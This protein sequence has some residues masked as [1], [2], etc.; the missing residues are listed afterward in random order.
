MDTLR[1][2]NRPL[3]HCISQLNDKLRRKWRK[4]HEV[5]Y[6]TKHKSFDEFRRSL[7]FPS[8]FERQSWKRSEGL[9]Q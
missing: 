9:V 2:F 3:L 1:T 6:H 5:T 4:G 8:I 7:F